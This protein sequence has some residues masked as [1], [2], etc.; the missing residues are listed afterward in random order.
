MRRAPEG[1]MMYLTYILWAI[2]RT[3]A[4][5]INALV[6]MIVIVAIG[7]KAWC[8]H[9]LECL[10]YTA[11]VIR[12]AIAFLMYRPYPDNHEA[13]QDKANMHEVLSTLRRAFVNTPTISRLAIVYLM[14]TGNAFPNMSSAS[15]SADVGA[16][17]GRQQ[18]QQPPEN[19]T[20]VGSLSS[21]DDED[22]ST[23]PAPV[24]VPIPTP[25]ADAD[26]QRDVG[27]DKC[28][29]MP[30]AESDREAVKLLSPAPASVSA[31]PGPEL[32]TDSKQSDHD[33]TNLLSAEAA[34]SARKRRASRRKKGPRGT[35]IAFM[36]KECSEDNT[37]NAYPDMA[38]PNDV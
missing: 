29:P 12:G 22:E 19:A 32:P 30:S 31:S 37:M 4:L 13:L 2:D 16:T 6:F 25:V 9:P 5:I 14:E 21:S 33:P 27:H 20:E 28:E 38:D 26:P 3:F 18:S 7:G 17:R 34:A 15:L 36:E 10:V 8:T 1:D 35:I 23:E 11:S 24:P